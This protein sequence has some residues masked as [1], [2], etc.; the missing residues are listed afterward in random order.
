MQWKK[1][2]LFMFLL[3]LFI[4]G[5]CGGKDVLINQIQ[6]EKTP[7][8]VPLFKNA[9]TQSTALELSTATF[10]VKTITPSATIPTIASSATPTAIKVIDLLHGRFLV[11]AQT[12][13]GDQ[14]ASFVRYY[15]VDNQLA[16]ELAL[17]DR[18]IE[19]SSSIDGRFLAYYGEGKWDDDSLLQYDGIFVYDTAF[20]QTWKLNGYQNCTGP[21]DWSSELY[22][23][24]ISCGDIKILALVNNHW[25]EE[26][27][28]PLL[29]EYDMMP[30]ELRPQLVAPAWSPNGKS[31]AYLMD[32][33]SN[34]PGMATGPYV[35]DVV[36]ITKPA[37][38]QSQTK[39]LDE[40]VTPISVLSW[41]MDGQTIYVANEEANGI[42]AVNIING[43]SNLILD[44]DERIYQMTWA[45]DYR[46]FW[47]SR[48]IGYFGQQS[49]YKYCLDNDAA[50]EEINGSGYLVGFV[51]IY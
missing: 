51:N 42:F 20:N 32:H 48:R 12:G 5:G 43:K 4:S 15:D 35:T 3:L 40:A 47:F 37:S 38:C 18:V 44:T 24:A 17:P 8:R 6:G 7:S 41:S 14:N 29:D 26:G 50:T 16:R 27:T 30:T 9:E 39:V 2:I 21:V 49:I 19:V 33:S 45:D 36:C 1:L 46:C 10:K 25:V 23:M 11:T 28:I 34:Q 31:I 22:R 13:T